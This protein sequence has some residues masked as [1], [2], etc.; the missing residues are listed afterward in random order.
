MRTNTIQAIVTAAVAALAATAS[1]ALAR[2]YPD[3]PITIV[4]GFAPG[5]P[6]DAAARLAA[7]WLSEKLKPYPFVMVSSNGFPAAV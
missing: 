4:S 6:T 7:Q 1:P 5:G 3:A 2:S